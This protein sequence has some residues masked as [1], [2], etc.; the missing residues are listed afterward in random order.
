MK[1]P[2][3]IVQDIIAASDFPHDEI[4]L[5]SIPK[6][7]NILLMKRK[8]YLQ[9]QIMVLMIMVTQILFHSCMVFISNLLHER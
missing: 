4:F 3:E 8:F 5:D 6:K 9:N 1:R 2:V 7:K